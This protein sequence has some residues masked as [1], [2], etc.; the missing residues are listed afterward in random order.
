MKIT[1][2]TDHP[3]KVRQATQLLGAITLIDD[4]LT[5]TGDYAATLTNSLNGLL[6][7]RNLGD[8]LRQLGQRL[9]APDE[10]ITFNEPLDKVLVDLVVQ[11]HANTCSADDDLELISLSEG[12]IRGQLRK[13]L[14]GASE[15]LRKALNAMKGALPSGDPQQLKTELSGIVKESTMSQS[16]RTTSS[17]ML[18]VA[19]A[20]LNSLLGELN[21][22]DFDIEA[23]DED[24]D[25]VLTATA[26]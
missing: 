24:L 2:T 17:G 8:E 11:T 15:K 20:Y 10:E 16:V 7:D 9:L 18:A 14:A 4:A 6:S 21:A 25:T 3:L 26:N 12:S 5:M 22:T 23:D 13:K 19:A 1:V